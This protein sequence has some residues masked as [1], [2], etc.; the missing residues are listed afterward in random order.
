MR[1]IVGAAALAAVVCLFH[2][3]AL[4]DEQIRPL[5]ISGDW[6]AAAHAAS[7]TAPPDVCL[8]TNIAS[9]FT[10]RSDED[11]LQIRVTNRSWSLPAN[12]TGIV[13]VDV[14]NFHKTFEIDDN[15]DNMVNAELPHDDAIAL[16]S[17][18]DNASSMSVTAG[19]GKPTTISLAGSTK[20]TNAFRTCA[21]LNSAGSGGGSNPF[22]TKP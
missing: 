10:V 1:G 20:A 3:P 5:A 12:V 9:G 4:A 16:F 19:S 18:M 6:A 7:M 21:G 13:E 14:G 15:T 2:P 8:A 11:G 22:G 17:A